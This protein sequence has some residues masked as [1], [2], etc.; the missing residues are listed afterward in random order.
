M[1]L[2]G[3]LAFMRGGG[4]LTGLAKPQRTPA[5]DRNGPGRDG[6]DRG[7]PALA[8]SATQEVADG[9]I[10]RSVSVAVGRGSTARPDLLG[11]AVDHVRLPDAPELAQ[12]LAAVGAIPRRG[13]PAH[14][15]AILLDL[16]TTGLQRDAG[17][18]PFMV[19]LSWHEGSMLV[20]KQWILARLSSEAAMLRE[21][22]AVLT[23]P[24]NADAALV[25]FN[26]ASFDLPVLRTRFVR[27]RVTRPGQP[28]AV[29]GRPHYDLLVAARR[30]WKGRRPD[31][32]LGTLERLQLSVE[33]QGD[34]HGSEIADAYWAWLRAPEDSRTRSVIDRIE[35]HNR[36]DLVSLAGLVADIGQR[37]SAPVDLTDA[38]R[39]ADHHVR[40]Q[41]PA[42]ALALLQ[43][44]VAA[45]GA[46]SGTRSDLASRSRLRDGVLLAA[47]LMRKAGDH[48]A[49]A[50]LWAAVCR[51]D[52]GHPDAHDRLAKHFEH[53]RR[54]PSAALT[55]AAGSASPCPRRIARLTR[56]VAATGA[57]PVP[58]DTALI[59][60]GARERGFDRGSGPSRT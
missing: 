6:A 47:E 24:D 53:R 10:R 4:G 60:A 38:V 26:G 22:A 1:S 13:F 35:A 27:H 33:R 50:A 54:E 48:R 17:C 31:C 11:G 9:F 57:E 55:I 8:S 56:K 41:R 5:T 21:V 12:S 46:A 19:G 7:T 45:F 39:A 30:M 44:V 42:R 20:V 3:R 37:L 34:V 29:D 40:Q 43:P 18:V 58:Y 28:T 15:P 51:R 25:T 49:A 2:S 23:Q 16:E 59:R 52:P 36:V 32:R 14:R